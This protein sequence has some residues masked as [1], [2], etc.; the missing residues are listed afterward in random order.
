[1]EDTSSVLDLQG[2]FVDVIDSIRKYIDENIAL[3]E[4]RETNE[5]TRRK[6]DYLRFF[7]GASRSLYSFQ[8]TAFFA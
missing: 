2:D 4:V 5:S 3:S 8:C 1:M 7:L 6:N